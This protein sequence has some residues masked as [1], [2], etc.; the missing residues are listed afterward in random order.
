[1]SNHVY[2]GVSCSGIMGNI[3]IYRKWDYLCLG[4]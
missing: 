1:M 4:D 3:D 2:N